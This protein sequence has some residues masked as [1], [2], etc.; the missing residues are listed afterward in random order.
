MTMNILDIH[1]GDHVRYTGN[2]V[3]RAG[4]RRRGQTAVVK[5]IS[6]SRNTIT[7]EFDGGSDWFDARP[8]ALDAIRTL[9][10]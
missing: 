1:K 10:G 6:V 8:S 4:R 9:E 2:G 7:I 5:H 3:D